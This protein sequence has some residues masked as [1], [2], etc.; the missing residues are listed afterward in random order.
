MD[1]PAGKKAAMSPQAA[2]NIGL[3]FWLPDE[4]VAEIIRVLLRGDFASKRALMQLAQTTRYLRAQVR[5]LAKEEPAMAS[6]TSKEQSELYKLTIEERRQLKFTAAMAVTLCYNPAALSGAPPESIAH[7]LA[8]SPWCEWNEP[9]QDEVITEKYL[10]ELAPNSPTLGPRSRE[11]LDSLPPA[12]IAIAASDMACDQKHF[13]LGQSVG[14]WIIENERYLS[15]AVAARLGKILAV[16]PLMKPSDF[17]ALV[18]EAT[19]IQERTCRLDPES[20]YAPL[21]LIASWCKTALAQPKHLSLRP[22]KWTR[23]FVPIENAALRINSGLPACTLSEVLGAILES[24]PSEVATRINEE[25]AVDVPRGTP[26][27]YLSLMRWINAAMLPIK[28][29]V[30]AF[31]LTE[32]DDDEAQL[33]KL[34]LHQAAD[35][36]MRLNEVLRGELLEVMPEELRAEL[37]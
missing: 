26:M 6:I 16:R 9:E 2:E 14:E 7:A 37:L 18:F 8:P 11:G 22:V 25:E 5:S 4:L 31:A 10:Y 28:S 1:G 15:D 3:L 33:R 32:A 20:S 29:A 24:M 19:E 23:R 35:L 34:T 21:A 36:T 17:V 13:F 12:L 27:Q 30:D